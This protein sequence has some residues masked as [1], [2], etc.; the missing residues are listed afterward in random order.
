MRGPVERA[1][2]RPRR[3]RIADECPDAALVAITLGDDRGAQPRRQRIHL[4]VRRRS[5]DFVDQAQ[6]V[7]ER[8]L[9]QPRRQRPA[10]TAG[11]RQRREQP[12]ERPVLTEVEQLVL[13]A[14]VVVQVAGRQVR[15]LGDVAHAGRG[16]ADAAERPRGGAQ[17]LDPAGVGAS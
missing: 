2:E 11:P 13:A 7:S 4:E 6:Y 10:S 12:V 9:V 8:Q 3:H 16:E 14:K 1:E 15:R 5:F 17:D